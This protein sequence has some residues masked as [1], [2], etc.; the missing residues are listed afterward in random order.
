MCTFSVSLLKFSDPHPF[1]HLTSCFNYHSIPFYKNILM[2]MC[3][4]MCE[5]VR[6][7]ARVHAEARNQCQI[8]LYCSPKLFFEKGSL[9]ALVHISESRAGEVERGVSLG[10]PGQPT[11]PNQRVPEQ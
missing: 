3:A 11:Y 5:C 8:F 2:L 6:A 7:Y 10:L 1:T 9:S 4:C